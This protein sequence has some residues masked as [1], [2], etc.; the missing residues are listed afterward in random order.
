MEALL[1]V[2]ENC[3]VETLR[4]SGNMLREYG[5]LRGEDVSTGSAVRVSVSHR[6]GSIIYKVESPQRRFLH[7]DL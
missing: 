6:P 3:A 4:L 5:L 1:L 2:S 7:A